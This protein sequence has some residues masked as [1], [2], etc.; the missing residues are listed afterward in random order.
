MPVRWTH[1]AQTDFLG[2]VEWLTAR[3]PAA[4]IRIG[5]RIL[6]AVDNL[7]GSPYIGRSGRSP[8]T[9]E[10]VVTRTPYLVVYAVEPAVVMSD[11]PSVVVLRVL[12]G[13]M[14]WPPKT[15]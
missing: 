9:R 7:P 15:G 11:P 3:N 4:A 2:I 10:L 6:A 14:L 12:H 8:E 1:P 13:A 5:R